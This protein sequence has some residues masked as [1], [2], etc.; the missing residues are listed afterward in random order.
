MYHVYWQNFIAE[1]VKPTGVQHWIGL[2]DITTEGAF[3]WTVDEELLDDAQ[4]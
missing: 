1:Y 2:H 4:K 3:T